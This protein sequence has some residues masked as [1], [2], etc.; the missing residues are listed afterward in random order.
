M[1]PS[2]GVGKAGFPL[3]LE[4]ML[5][6]K[7]AASALGGGFKPVHPLVNHAK[8][9]TQREDSPHVRAGSSSASSS[10]PPESAKE[11][12][13]KAAGLT[14][15]GPRAA[16]Q[17]QAVHG[18]QPAFPSA[19][20]GTDYTVPRMTKFESVGVESLEDGDG[21]EDLSNERLVLDTFD[22]RT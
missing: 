18:S 21:S 10:G 16:N 12:Q 2:K 19:E 17:A 6:I 3:A 20:D 8:A 7:E 22:Y 1:N 11:E 5:K 13:G 9:A 15:W 4:P 14:G